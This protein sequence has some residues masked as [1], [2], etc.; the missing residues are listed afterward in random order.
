MDLDLN[1]NFCAFVI[2]GD[3]L[4]K[5]TPLSPGVGREG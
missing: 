2:L 1:P 5:Y 4:R 3:D